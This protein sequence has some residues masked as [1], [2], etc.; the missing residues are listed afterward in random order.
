MNVGFYCHRLSCSRLQRRS[1]SHPILLENSVFLARKV[2]F[3]TGRKRLSFQALRTCCG[4]GK[5]LASFLRFWALAARR[6]SS[7]APHGPR[8]RRRPSPRIR[9]KCAKSISTFFRKRIEIAYCL[10]FAMSRATWRASSCS[11]R[12]ILR[13]S[14]FGQH[15]NFDGQ[16]WHVCYKA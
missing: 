2:R 6:N 16:A 12:V 7:F 14:A 3:Q 11:S 9:F 10:V 4:A 8:N 5:I 13:A 1:G 15:F